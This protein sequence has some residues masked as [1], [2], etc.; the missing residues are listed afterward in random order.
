MQR[1]ARW[2]LCDCK[3]SVGFPDKEGRLL[4]DG[5]LGGEG[6]VGAWDGGWDGWSYGWGG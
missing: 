1:G 6:V 3:G 5:V 4:G 2:V